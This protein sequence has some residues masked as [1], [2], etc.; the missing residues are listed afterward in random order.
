MRA[1]PAHMAVLQPSTKDPPASTV[2]AWVADGS[3]L[4]T[5]MVGVDG[6][7]G[8]MYYLAVEPSASG[9]GI[10]RSLVR[11]CEEWVLARGIPK[12]MLMVRSDNRDVLGFYDALGYEV[13]EVATLGR[14]LDGVS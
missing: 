9:T 13:N 14:R 1:T 3:L 10:G 12:L 4:G 6:H 7:R 2:L 5:A 8:W 11:A